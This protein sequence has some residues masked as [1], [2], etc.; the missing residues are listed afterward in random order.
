MT[1]MVYC[2]KNKCLVGLLHLS[3]KAKEPVGMVV[4]HALEFSQINLQAT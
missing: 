2:L 3:Q 1:V 4:C